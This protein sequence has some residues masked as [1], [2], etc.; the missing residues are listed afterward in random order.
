MSHRKLADIKDKDARR[1]A[2]EQ[3]ASTIQDMGRLKGDPD[4]LAAAEGELEKI[5]QDA[6]AG[7]SLVNRMNAGSP[8][9][10]SP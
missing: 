7:Q 9:L 1:W 3:A 5:E 10:Q 2:I 4:L 6:R 8:Q